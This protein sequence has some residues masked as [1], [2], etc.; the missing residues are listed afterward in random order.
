MRFLVIEG[1]MVRGSQVALKHT[2]HDMETRTLVMEL[3]RC[4]IK[5]WVPSGAMGR[6]L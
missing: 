2:I 4:A 5:R 1:L 6:R 3:S